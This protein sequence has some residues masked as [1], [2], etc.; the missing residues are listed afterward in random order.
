MTLAMRCAALFLLLPACA[1]AAPPQFD[2]KQPQSPTLP[3]PKWL[4]LIDHGQ[5]DPRLKGYIAP[6]GLK[7]EIVAEEP[8]VVNPVG[9]TFDTDG[10]LL[11]LEWKPSADPRDTWNE[12]AETFIYKDGTQRKVATMKKRVKDVLNVLKWNSDK[13]LYDRSEL[14]LEDELPSSILLYDGWIYLSS[15]G[16]VR[17]YRQS[18]PGG[19][20]DVKEVIAQGFCGFHHHQVSGLTLG[21]DG[22][23]YITA[24]DDDNYV[25]GSDGSRATVLRTGAVFRCR[26]D[27]S[28][29]HVYSIGYRNPYRDVAFDTAFNIFHVDNDNEDGSKFTG[30]RLMH[31]AE[32]SDFG[33]RLFTGA[34]CCKPDHVRGAVFGELPGKMPAMLKTGRG[35]PAGLLIY[36][37]TQFPEHFRG[38]FYY[39][40]VFRKLIRA[41]RV[42]PDGS[43]FQAVEEFEFLK[44]NDP[45]FRP[46][47]M[48]VG[49]DGAM[50]VCDWRTD[51]G[52]AGRLWGDGV[53]GRIYRISWAG[54]QGDPTIPMRPMNSWKFATPGAPYAAL[55]DGLASPDFS[56]QLR[57]QAALVLC[58]RE[59]PDVLR[60]LLL[61]HCDD[62]D[63]TPTTRL[64]RLGALQSVWDGEVRNKYLALLRDPNPDVIRL[65]ADGLALNGAAGDLEAHNALV[66]TLHGS[67]A[68]ADRAISLAIG[69]IGAPGAEDVLATVFKFDSGPDIYL[70]DGIIR[71][72]ERLGTRGVHRLLDVANSGV[73]RDRDKVVAAFL[74]LRTR[75]GA[76]ALPYLLQNPHLGLTQRVDLIRSYANYLLDPALGP[77][78]LIQIL[79]AQ[80]QAAPEVKRAGLETLALFGPTKGDNGAALLIS[81]IQDPDESVRLAALQAVEQ[82]RVAQAVPY[83][84]ARLGPG[85][86]SMERAALVK[87]LRV[88]GD[89]GTVP[90]LTKILQENLGKSAD[91]TALRLEAVRSLAQLEPK[92]ALPFAEKFLDQPGEL[93]NE[94][95]SVLGAQAGGAKLVAERFVAQKLPRD[96]L[97]QV[98]DGLRKH[99]AKEPELNKLLTEV[100]KGG[101]LLSLDKAQID[102]VQSLVKSKGNPVRGRELYLNAKTLACINCHKLEG[103]GGSV[104]PD[105]TR[106]WETLSLEKVMESMI[107]PSKEIK[108][109]YQSYR[110]TTAKGLTYIGLKVAQ[111]P[112]GV[113]IKEATGK[114]ITVP[115]AEIEEVEV[116]KQSLMPD[117]VIS[118]LSFDQ[119]IDL[120]AFLRDRAAQESLRGLPLE[121]WVVG[122]FQG[123][124][125]SVL[126][127]EKLADPSSKGDPAWRLQAAEPSGYLD[128][129]AALERERVVA[130]SLTYVY[131]AKP[132]KVTLFFGGTGAARV[133]LGGKLVHEVG[134]T[135]QAKAD[136]DR[137]EVTLPGGWSAL[138]VKTVQSLGAHGFYLRL[139]GGEGIRVSAR[140]EK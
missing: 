81:L 6:E 98:T 52:G 56:T 46:C 130:Y 22:W 69:R 109:G 117:N 138:L 79:R 139:S 25:E 38:L 3:A 60:R 134:V 114:E 137:V 29:M 74:T 27:G 15:R 49:P 92:A 96:V 111:S 61:A 18:K 76:D 121:Y 85:R 84:V 32:E 10:T 90:P 110:V 40:D 72:L 23:L 20:Y 51:S 112:S 89:R 68:A 42:E 35:S 126:P 95:I 86:S 87:T 128:L 119:F 19:K 58:G 101:L 106:V 53:H 14:V 78:P 9:M 2:I 124:L 75:P 125:Q 120:V 41:Y 122:P 66:S 47:E 17:R 73:D 83:L 67:D 108:E 26:P 33:W 44:S 93:Q 11:V 24:G 21:I 63:Q 59:Y 77:E 133:W 13:R 91:D 31:V 39:P 1:F 45:L 136:A 104:G 16:T 82:G 37:D 105:L 28:K 7:I 55:A 8:A 54:T 123:D 30:C 107:E 34:R 97:P 99:L 80:L 12:F 131:S 94:A 132:Q 116:S 100:M 135:R 140:Q 64:L 4:K 71:A 70:S 118:Q 127:P 65:A 5:F 113:T 88:F 50:Y 43:T 57:A 103:V 62:P 36:N 129:R 48:V 115:S 102:K